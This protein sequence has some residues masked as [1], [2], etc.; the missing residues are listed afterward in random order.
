MKFLCN[1]G[2]EITCKAMCKMLIS[3]EE[4]NEV[5]TIQKDV[6]YICAAM[7]AFP[8]RFP[9]TR[10]DTGLKVVILFLNPVSLYSMQYFRSSNSTF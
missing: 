1:C 5:E 9:W 4:E 8:W 2:E 7:L 3:L 6:A 10:F